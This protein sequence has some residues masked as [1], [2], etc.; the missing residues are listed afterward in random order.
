MQ[1]ELFKASKNKQLEGLLK[2][3]LLEAVFTEGEL[4]TPRAFGDNVQERIA[5][6][7]EGLLVQMKQPIFNYK[8]DYGRRQ[9]ADFSF[10]DDEGYNYIVDVKSHR[11][12]K[13]SH[14][15]PNLV[16]VKRLI[17]LYKRPKQYFVLLLISYEVLDG[18]A[19]TSEVIFTPI[20]Q[21]SWQCLRLGNLGRG[22]IQISNASKI[23][24]APEKSREEWMLEF[25]N[26]A[27]DFYP[28]EI[29]KMGELIKMFEKEKIYWTPKN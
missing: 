18:K 25:C 7:C 14:N 8:S 9:M 1:S 11:I 19:V 5:E 21:L 28:A 13:K 27:L 23:I 24:V 10:E 16:S 15:M 22:Q 6:K 29:K 2:T 4:K 26:K 17:D 12:G 20:E 3:Y